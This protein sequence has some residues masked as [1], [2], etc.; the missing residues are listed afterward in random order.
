MA[1]LYGKCG[2]RSLLPASS[3]VFGR[4][5]S[6]VV[7]SRK[8]NFAAKKQAVES[9]QL[10]TGTLMKITKVKKRIKRICKKIVSKL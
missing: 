9:A 1:F 6:N 7:L 8:S 5:M 10:S 2:F 3:N 4:V